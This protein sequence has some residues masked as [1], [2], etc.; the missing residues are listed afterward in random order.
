MEFGERA[1]DEVWRRRPR[2][3]VLAASRHQWRTG[4]PG[5]VLEPAAEDGCATFAAAAGGQR[6]AG[7]WNK[8]EMAHFFILI[9][10]D[11]P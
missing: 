10:L 11:C 8:G 6:A 5:T 3:R 7:R 4:S 2:W 9:S 1:A